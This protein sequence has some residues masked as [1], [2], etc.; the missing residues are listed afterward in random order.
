MSGFRGNDEVLD[1]EI[2]ALERIARIRLRRAAREMAELDKDLRGLK[3]ERALRKARARIPGTV[4]E[5]ASYA[6]TP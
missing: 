5:S 2:E 4:D 3:A 6:A 1:A